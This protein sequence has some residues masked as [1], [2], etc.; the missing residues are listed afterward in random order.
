MKKDR[1]RDKKRIAR[2]DE[3]NVLSDMGKALG[4]SRDY[5]KGKPRAI[6]DEK[7]ARSI[8]HEARGINL[9]GPSEYAAPGEAHVKVV[10]NG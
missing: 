4:W 6:N 2:R 9:P 8:A 5:Y 3:T 1:A 7:E 10:K